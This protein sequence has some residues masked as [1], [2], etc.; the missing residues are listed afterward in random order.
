[1]KRGHEKKDEKKEHHRNPEALGIAGFTLG[2]MSI[3][4]LLLSPS[5]GV[6]TAI[7][8]GILC[9][10]QQKKV[11]T[12]TARTGLILNITGLV[13]NI[14]FWVLLIVYITPFLL[15]QVPTV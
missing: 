4:M 2:I 5:F 8:G 1:M 10:V 13:I 7:V 11:K 9:L 12:K 14:L 6:I 3:V 15:S